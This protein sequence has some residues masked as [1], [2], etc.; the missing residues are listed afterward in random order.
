MFK[1]LLVDTNFTE[2]NVKSLKILEMF[3]SVPQGTNMIYSTVQFSVCFLDLSADPQAGL[4]DNLWSAGTKD[5]CSV[6]RFSL[7]ASKL[8]QHHCLPQTGQRRVVR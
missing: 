4:I 1:D 2:N 3:L 7:P 5:T 8:A 6:G